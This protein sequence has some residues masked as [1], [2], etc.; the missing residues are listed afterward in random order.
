MLKGS[1]K[2]KS[3]PVFNKHRTQNRA[4]SRGGNKLTSDGHEVIEP[5]TEAFGMERFSF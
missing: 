1:L 2:K 5:P 3:G 4:E